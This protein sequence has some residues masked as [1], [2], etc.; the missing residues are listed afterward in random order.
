MTMNNTNKKK[1]L[2]VRVAACS[3]AGPC[4]R[5]F[6]KMGY[7]VFT[8]DYRT[9]IYFSNK[10]VRRAAKFFPSIKKWVKKDLNKR[11]MQAVENYQPDYLFSLKGETIEPE[12]IERVKKRGIITINWF[13]DYIW[14]WDGIEKL[15]PVYDFFFCQDHYVLGLLWD[16]GLKN[17]F[18]LPSAAELDKNGSNPFD[19][20]KEEYNIA[21]CG[22]YSK[23]YYEKRDKCLNSVK[24]LGLNI[25]G[26]GGWD[27]TEL[28]DNFRGVVPSDEVVGTYKRSK[29]AV[30]VQYNEEPAEGV[31]MR[32]FEA[33]AGGALLISDSGRA[34]ILRVFKD[35]D[36]FVSF[37]DGDTKKLRELVEYYL[38]HPD[39]RLKIARQ[40]HEKTKNKH[41]FSVRMREMFD[42]VNSRS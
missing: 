42:V 9:G 16:R 31:S 30:N 7:D 10:L 40:G 24:D 38:A 27:K 6:I 8:F 32:P 37:P 15:A 14:A 13:P 3:F 1:I 5:A 21:V 26:I 22:S 25:W 2:I 28:K 29:I 19:N 39:E 11:F 17:C 33:T 23:D 35:G 4:Q 41:T 12:T 36:E 20:R 18:Y 34:D